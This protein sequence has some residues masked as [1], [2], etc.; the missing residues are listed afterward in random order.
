MGENFNLDKKMYRLA[1]C[2][3]QVDLHSI[4]VR[5]ELLICLILLSSKAD[6]LCL[7]RIR[8]SLVKRTSKLYSVACHV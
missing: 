7:N 8:N 2:S 3:N 5:P 4:V 1:T 6:V